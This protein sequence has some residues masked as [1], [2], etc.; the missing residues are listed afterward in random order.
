VKEI[1]VLQNQRIGDTLQTTPLLAGLREKHAPCRI[2][3]VANRL[4]ADLRLQGLVDETIVLDQNALCRAFKDR[5]RSL[6]AGFEEARAFLAPLAAHEWDLVIDVPADPVMHLVASNLPRARAVRGATLG[7]AR[8][9]AYSH[10]EVMLLYTIGLCREV[11]RFN[12]VDLQNL[13]A[14]VRPREPRLELPVDPASEAAADRLLSDGGI[15]PGGELVIALQAGASEERK[16]WGEERFTA[17]ARAAAER[18]GARVVV[19]GSAAEREMAERIGSAAGAR[20]LVAAG[21]TTVA[22]LGALLRRCR[23]LVTHATGTM[24]VAAAV[25]TRVI[26]LSV[27]PVSFRE[28]GPYQEGSLV[29][30]GE[31][32][33]APCNFNAV[34]HHYS[35]RDHI[36]PEMVLRTLQAVRDGA[37]WSTLDPSAFRGV[38]L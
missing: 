27:G 28:T 24:H 23:A 36:T 31:I 2:T 33:C 19:C 14:G 11:N 37:E 13:L 25:G 16:R 18:L 21:R 38:R 32:E 22:E 9:L 17:L 10:P 29:F 5:T 7:P 3:L 20:A 34:C 4:F 15:D 6:A 1:L 12:L 8:R 35:C 26:D 30:E